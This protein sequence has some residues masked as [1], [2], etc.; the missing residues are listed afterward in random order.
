MTAMDFRQY[1]SAIGRF[2]GM[3]RL[4]E[5]TPNWTPYRFAFNNPVVFADPTGLSESKGNI[6]ADGLTNE[7]WLAQNRPK[8]SPYAQLLQIEKDM[9]A[10]GV[11]R[12]TETGTYSL[13]KPNSGRYK[14]TFLYNELPY[15]VWNSLTTDLSPLILKPIYMYYAESIY[16]GNW[17]K[18]SIDLINKITGLSATYADA[19]NDYSHLNS[20][21]VYKYGTASSSAAQLT[22]ANKVFQLKVAKVAK[23]G[24]KFLTGVSILTNV[25]QVGGDLYEG[26][27][28]SAGT[29]ATVATIALTCSAIPVYGW[30]VA[31]GIGIADA[32]WG[33]KFYNFV[34]NQ[35]TKK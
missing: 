19:L 23:I 18:E 3:D 1:D 10:R 26:K 24:G 14:R 5:M 6:G 11:Y 8:D 2:V 29:R 28:Y 9:M 4:A 34:E 32:I 12:D 16:D 15:Q 7:Q 33:D 20:K 22:R 25:A 30:A 27:Y 35:M 31:G 13:T 17:P 21:Y